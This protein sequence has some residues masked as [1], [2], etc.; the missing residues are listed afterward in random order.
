MADFTTYL[1]LRIV[2]YS[3]VILAILSL[4][5]YIING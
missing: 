3:L 4:G 5:E 2:Q 1:L